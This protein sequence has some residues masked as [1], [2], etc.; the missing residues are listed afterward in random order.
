M[1]DKV[2]CQFAAA[3]YLR[4]W[5]SIDRGFLPFKKTI[6]DPLSLLGFLK[7]YGVNRTLTLRQ[8]SNEVQSSESNSKPTTEERLKPLSNALLS[9]KL[10]KCHQP[11]DAVMGDVDKLY[12][13]SPISAAS[14]CVWMLNQKEQ[15]SQE[16]EIVMSDGFAATGLVRLV[17]TATRREQRKKA[18]VSFVDKEASFEKQRKEYQRFLAVWLH[19]RKNHAEVVQ[20]GCQ[21]VGDSCFAA[22]IAKYWKLAPELVSNWCAEPWF[23]WRVFDL[24]LHVVAG[25]WGS[26]HAIRRQLSDINL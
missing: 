1:V 10:I 17:D 14:K 20:V 9:D 19:A 24:T 6:E 25:R 22:R 18:D 7:T 13:F 5:L 12:K 11:V 2:I 8:S 4:T 15:N 23:Q 16:N 3:V 26:K 21:A